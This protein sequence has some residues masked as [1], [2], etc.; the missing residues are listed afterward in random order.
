MFIVILILICNIEKYQ[1]INIFREKNP[2]RIELEIADIAH[3]S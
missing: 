1:Y 2:Y 3:R